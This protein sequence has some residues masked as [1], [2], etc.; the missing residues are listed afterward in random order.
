MTLEQIKDYL[1]GLPL[2][3]ALWWFMEN[4]NE[5]SPHRSEIFFYLRERYRTYDP[6]D[7]F[8]FEKDLAAAERPAKQPKPPKPE[9]RTVIHTACRYCNLDIEGH[10]PFKRGQ[11]RDRGNNTV[12]NDG[13]H[14]HAP[15]PGA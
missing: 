12:C 4:V 9:P 3:R 1:N 15:V 10:H 6:K 7:E 2:V 11:W 13:K 8:K 5:D 14:K